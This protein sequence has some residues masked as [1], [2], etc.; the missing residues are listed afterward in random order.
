M[1]KG[2]KNNG[3]ENN[4]ILKPYSFFNTI[5]GVYVFHLIIT[6]QIS[7]NPQFHK[8]IEIQWTKS[9][10]QYITAGK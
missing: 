2:S 10:V 9:F 4:L 3:Y 1:Q 8:E 5:K 6:F 7:R